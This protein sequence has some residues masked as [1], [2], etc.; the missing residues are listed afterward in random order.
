MKRRVPTGNFL[1]WEELDQQE[2]LRRAAFIERFCPWLCKPL[3]LTAA[4]A[5][6]R[7]GIT[8]RQL[9]ALTHHAGLPCVRLGPG[10]EMGYDAA[11]L[12]AW[13]EQRKG[14]V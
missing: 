14:A 13:L 9:W 8:G 3:L 11:E 6:R 4:E 10:E 12:D 7:L 1:T 2:R 5:A